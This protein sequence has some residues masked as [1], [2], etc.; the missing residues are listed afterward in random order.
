[1][2]GIK[3]VVFDI[4]GTIIEDHG[5]VV[6]AFAKALMENGI[7]FAEDELKKWKGASKREVIRHF[8]QQVEPKGDVEQQVES[9]YRRFRSELETC[10]MEKLVPIPGTVEA[11]RW[12]KE[13]GILLAT[14]TGFYREISD[15]V[16][17]QTG[18]QDFFAANISSSDVRQGRPA[19]FM[20][21]HAMEATGVQ[22]VKEVINVGDTPL[23]LQSGSNA[24]VAGVV[25][26]LTGTHSRESLQQERHTHI[27]TSIADLPELI[28]REF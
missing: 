15:L 10:Y 28:A 7:P 17:R 14:S 13:R 5:E 16:L 4:A 23:D 12:L 24:G 1:M 21:F 20:I 18:W 27:I 6:R 19:P 26:V 25:G 8:I 9:S 3:L 11:F 2:S 22:N